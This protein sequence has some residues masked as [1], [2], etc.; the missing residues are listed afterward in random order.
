MKTKDSK[1]VGYIIKTDKDKYYAL[2]QNSGGYPYW[3]SLILSAKLFSSEEK[4]I[5]I[6]V[7]S[8]GFT[9]GSRMSNGTRFPP[10]MIHT[11]AKINYENPIGT[12]T[13]SVVPLIIG[14]SVL[15]KKFV[16][17]IIRPKNKY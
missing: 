1:I 13:I 8:S 2:D 16:G 7:D 3:S 6:V 14:E 10:R 11:A 17:K 4:A 12:T 15:S 9:V 5:K